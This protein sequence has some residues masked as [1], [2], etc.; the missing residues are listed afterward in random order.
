LNQPSF[1]RAFLK[2]A[3][4]VGFA[5]GSLP[6]CTHTAATWVALRG[7]SLREIAGF[8][9]QSDT[10]MVER[11]CAHRHADHRN[12]GKA[13]LS[14]KIAASGAAS[15]PMLARREKR[16]GDSLAARR[17]R[18]HQKCH[19]KTEDS[20]ASGSHNPLKDMVGAA[21]IEPATPTMSR[22]G[23]PVRGRQI[24]P[25]DQRLKIGGRSRWR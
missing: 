16:S 4:R 20:V 11:A 18:R 21:G 24:V 17:W 13:A 23:K 2:P 8:P 12:R 14:E 6:P 9:G 7:V 10:R 3:K 1:Y 15:N 19:Q 5:P 25:L 22:N